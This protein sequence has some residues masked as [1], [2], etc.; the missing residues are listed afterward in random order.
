[1]FGVE[2]GSTVKKRENPGKARSNI[3]R[4]LIIMNTTQIQT[5]IVYINT[6]VV[7]KNS[8]WYRK[9]KFLIKACMLLSLVKYSKNVNHIKYIPQIQVQIHQLY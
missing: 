7:M 3:S 6:P 5:Y 2:T 8:Y 1:M 4:M 9:R